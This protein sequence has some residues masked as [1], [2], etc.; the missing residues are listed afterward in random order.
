MPK[1]EMIK[2][3]T[4][5]HVGIGGMNVSKKVYDQLREMEEKGIELDGTGTDYPEA[6]QWFVDN[7]HLRDC[8]DV[9][10]EVKSLR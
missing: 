4:T 3:K 8:H 10:Y 2:V 6:N 1:I 5:F 7:I 9:E